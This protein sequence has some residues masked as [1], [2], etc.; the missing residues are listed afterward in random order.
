MDVRYT[1]H[2]EEKA[3]ERKIPK[4][5]IENVLKNPEEVVAGAFGRKIAHKFISGKLLRIVYEEHSETLVIITVY[6]TEP[7][8]Y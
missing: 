2:A 4:R 8:R 5:L 7:N 6:Y 3:A 1:R